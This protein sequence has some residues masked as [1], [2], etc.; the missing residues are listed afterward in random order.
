MTGELNRLRRAQ[1]AMAGKTSLQPPQ[2]PAPS[3]G[4]APSQ[5]PA[6]SAASSAAP[7]IPVKAAPVSKNPGMANAPRNAP[8]PNTPGADPWAQHKPRSQ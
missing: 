3:Q 6:Q 7:G 2:S 1:P 4:P 5:A 8:F